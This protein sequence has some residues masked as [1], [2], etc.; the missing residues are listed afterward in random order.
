MAIILVVEDE[1][2]IAF[3]TSMVLEDAGFT[4]ILAQDGETGLTKALASAPDLI[5]T[6]Y[7]MPRMNGIKMIKALRAAGNSTPVI[8]ATAI[9]EDSLPSNP[10]PVHD[11]YLGKPY[12]DAVLLRTVRQFLQPDR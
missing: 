7:M 6:D 12:H 3:G 10:D 1:V 4:V 11:A 8:L 9:P 5:I 2:I